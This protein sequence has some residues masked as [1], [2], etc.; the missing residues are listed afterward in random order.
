MRVALSILGIIV[1]GFIIFL[2]GREIVVLFFTGE[3]VD[4]VRSTGVDFRSTD[5]DDYS[6]Y[7]SLNDLDSMNIMF[8]P[9]KTLVIS[10]EV[11]HEIKTKN[12]IESRKKIRIKYLRGIAEYRILLAL[13]IISLIM[14]LFLGYRVVQK[15]RG[16]G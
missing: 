4:Y 13:I 14:F 1:F 9:E 16:E 7:I 10:G 12:Q 5:E 6:E 3:K 11:F 8:M 2:F 15:F